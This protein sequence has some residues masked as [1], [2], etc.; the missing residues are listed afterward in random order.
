MPEQ[1]RTNVFEQTPAE[2]ESFYETTSVQMING[3]YYRVIVAYEIGIRTHKASAIPPRTEKNDYKKYAEVYT[4]Y[5]YNEKAI[6]V[7]EP[8]R[9]NRRNLGNKVRTKSEGYA[10]QGNMDNDDPHFGLDIGQFY[11]GGFTDYEIDDKDNP[12]FLKNNVDQLSL[13]FELQQDINKCYG[14]KAIKVIQDQKGSDAYFEVPGGVNETTDFGRGALIIR[15]IN[16]DNSKGKPQIYTNY[17]EASASVDAITKVCY[18]F[19]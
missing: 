5:A 3:C 4:F 12:V 16:P 2:K 11:L 14:N 15:K 9:E 6:E 7:I 8:K 13:W 18:R 17:L 10:G 1:S 19:L